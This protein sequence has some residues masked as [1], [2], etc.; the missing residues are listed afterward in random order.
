[1]DD[2][3]K[4]WSEVRASFLDALE[5]NC[6]IVGT[7]LNNQKLFPT[8]PGYDDSTKL[9]EYHNQLKTMAC[10]L[11]LN[12]LLDLMRHHSVQ[13]YITSRANLID[14]YIQHDLH[15]KLPELVISDIEQFAD[16]IVDYHDDDY[17]ISRRNRLDLEELVETIYHP[18]LDAINKL[19]KSKAK[20]L[21]LFDDGV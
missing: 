12:V 3:F 2:L 14:T 19:I 1:M 8:H 18:E 9:A 16:Q 4:N 17:D 7:L 10:E 6:G 20:Q 13:T 11:P 15:H 21:D 5:S